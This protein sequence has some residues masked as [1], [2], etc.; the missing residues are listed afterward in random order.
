[1]SVFDEA[2][3]AIPEVAQAIHQATPDVIAWRVDSKAPLDQPSYVLVGI[4]ASEVIVSGATWG[5]LHRQ[6]Q[7]TLDTTNFLSV[8]TL[9]NELNELIRRQQCDSI[10]KPK[11]SPGSSETPLS[12]EVIFS[13]PLSLT[14]TAI[15]SSPKVSDSV[16]EALR[17]S[18]TS[19]KPNCMAQV[20]P[21]ALAEVLSYLESQ[22]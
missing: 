9:V 1:M 3:R 12:V 6:E 5:Y 16:L 22:Q 15:E 14:K 13:P 18:M 7:H 17:F 8:V 19:C 10:S 11:A 21:A 4:T 2:T 20:S